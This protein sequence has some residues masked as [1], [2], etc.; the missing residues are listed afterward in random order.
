MMH[1]LLYNFLRDVPQA[2]AIWSSLIVLA[3]VVIAAVVARPGRRPPVAGQSAGP[4][5]AA[6]LPGPAAAA[7][8]PGPVDDPGPEDLRRYAEEV[9][10]AAE[11]AAG[12]ARRHRDEWLA[13]QDEVTAAGQKLDGAEAAVRRLTRATAF[14]SPATPRTPTEYADR[15]RFLHRAAMAA[16]WRRELSVT[17]LSD[18]FAHRNGWDPRRH[19]VEQEFVLRMVVRDLLRS[20]HRSAVE[21]ERTAWRA[22]EV[23]AV[24]ARSLREEAFAAAVRVHQARY[25]PVPEPA[26]D[27]T[28]AGVVRR[29]RTASRWRAARA[30]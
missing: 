11:R 13:A 1:A 6:P 18:V 3:M 8:P 5:G 23:S 27:R 12:T 22:A 26:P 9:A 30:G 10:V 4:V 16:Y 29:A 19:P 25:A 24:A 14:G 28:A 2:A 17:E 15:E 7:P 21:R 20:G